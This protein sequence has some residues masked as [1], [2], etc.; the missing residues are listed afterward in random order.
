MRYFLHRLGLVRHRY[1]RDATVS[2]RANGITLV[3]CDLCGR[4]VNI[5]DADFRLTDG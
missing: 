1:G 3:L 5:R 4:N 2:A